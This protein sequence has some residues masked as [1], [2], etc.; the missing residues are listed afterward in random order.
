V[1]KNFHARYRSPWPATTLEIKFFPCILDCLDTT[2]DRLGG[3][4][5]I[6]VAAVFRRRSRNDRYMMTTITTV[7][8]G[9]R[10]P[11]SY[12]SLAPRNACNQFVTRAQ[13][14]RSHAF[15]L[16]LNTDTTILRKNV[17]VS[18]SSPDRLQ[19]RN[20]EQSKHHKTTA[21]NA[22]QLNNTA[23]LF[24]GGFV[25]AKKIISHKFNI[26]TIKETWIAD[27]RNTGKIN[28][29]AHSAG[30]Y[31]H[32]RV[33]TAIEMDSYVFHQHFQ[34]V[35]CTNGRSK[36]PGMYNKK[37]SVFFTRGNVTRTNSKHQMRRLIF[38]GGVGF[39]LCIREHLNSLN[40]GFLLSWYSEAWCHQ[41]L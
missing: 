6:S 41:H 25:T 20:Y 13:E 27:K 12:G 34:S 37:L 32:E 18:V 24:F 1:K 5:P 19:R 21:K 22:Q 40:F 17:T 7:R 38:G 26:W 2:T 16:T 23:Q 39:N 15:L 9:M 36:I 3:A 4:R 11:Y 33:I 31:T 29:S 10:S 28:K 30:L 14:R 35:E 8:R